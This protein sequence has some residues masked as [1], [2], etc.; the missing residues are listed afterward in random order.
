V[1]HFVPSMLR[2]FLGHGPSALALGSCDALRY[3]FCSGEA[4]PSPLVGDF[5]AHAPVGAGLHNLY[6]PTEAA[7]DVTHWPC[8]A[9]VADPLPIGQA[10]S[11]T[12]LY[13]LD[14][15]LEPVPVGVVGE[16]WIGGVQVSRGYLGRPGL[17]A[18]N[19]MADPHGGVAGAR[20][21]RTGDLARRRPDGA[22]VYL[23]RTDHQVKLRG[24]RIELGEI[25]T[26]LLGHGSVLAAAVLL[27]EDRTGDPRLVAYVVAEGG[28]APPDL[29]GH[30]RVTLAEHMVPSDV[31]VLDALPVTS[32]G[33]L[34][35][36][37]LPA[38]SVASGSG[39][40]AS[41]GPEEEV[42]RSV[43]AGVLGREEV[44]PEDNF[45]ALGGH[46][47]LA[48]QAV[49]RLRAALHVDMPANAVFENPTP[50]RIAE[51]ARSGRVG[52]GT[53]I[54]RR[55]DDATILPSL[56]QRQLWFL[57][58]L[59][60]SKAYNVPDGFIVDGP[61]DIIALSGA[62]EDIMS[63]HEALRAVM[64]ERDGEPVVEVLAPP[65][66]RIGVDRLVTDDPAELDSWF[67]R[68][69]LH[70]FKIDIEPPIRLAVASLRDG[71]HAIAIVMHHLATDGASAPVLYRDLSDAYA[72]RKSGRRFDREDPP[73]GYYDWAMWQRDR[74][75]SGSMEAAV[76][77]VR[78]RLA[79]APD[80]L[81]LP[82]DFQRPDAGSFDGAMLRVAIP[83]DLSAALRGC[84]RETGST[85]FMV[86]AAGLGAFLGRLCDQEDL[87]I[88][89]P[90]SGRD[91][92]ETESLV[93]FMVNTIPLRLRPVRST[94]LAEFL[95]ATRNDV[96]ASFADGDLPLDRVVQ[97]LS[98]NRVHSRTPLFQVLLVL[99][100]ADRMSLELDQASVTPVNIDT[101]SARYD[102]TF[103][104]DD[105]G[106]GL[107]LVLHYA[108]DLFR[109]DTAR[110]LADGLNRVLRALAD[111]RSKSIR[112]LDLLDHDGRCAETSGP[113]VRDLR[114]APDG[115]LVSRFRQIATEHAGRPAVEEMTGATR[116]Y[117]ELDTLSDRVAAGLRQ[118]G[119][120]RGDRIGLFME[121]GGIQVAAMLAVLKAGGAYVP[122]EPE[123]PTIRL[124]M[125]LDAAD[126]RIVV[127]DQS[128]PGGG[129]AGATDVR[130]LAVDTLMKAE[131]TGADG[132][133]AVR[134][135]AEVA[136][137]P[138]ISGVSGQPMGVPISDRAILRSAVD[139]GFTDV[140]SGRRV[141]YISSAASDAVVH[142]IW[143]P[144]LNG[145]VCVVV[146]QEG[147][148]IPAKLGES[149][150]VQGIDS[151]YLTSEMFSQAAASEINILG[152]AREVL[153][154]GGAVDVE[155]AR[156]AITRWPSVRFVHVHGTMETAGVAS[157][158]VVEIP[159]SIDL[160]VPIGRPSRAT[161]LYVLDQDLNPVPRGGHGELYVGGEGLA[162]GYLRAPARTA[163]SFLADPFTDRSGARMYRTRELVRRRGDGALE[164][165][166]RLDRRLRLQGHWVDPS[167]IEVAIRARTPNAAEVFVDVLAPDDVGAENEIV[168]WVTG[169]AIDPERERELRSDLSVTLPAWMVPARVIGLEALPIGKDG[170]V[171]RALLP[172]LGTGGEVAVPRKE[173]ETETEKALAEIWSGLL[174]GAPVEADDTFFDVGGHSLLGVKLVALV[175]QHLGVTLELRAVFEHSGLREMATLIDRS[176]E[177]GATNVPTIK[178]RA[179]RGS[180]DG[181]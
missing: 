105:D 148:T 140:T 26:A 159:T 47:L 135:G 131:I 95:D 7:I 150:S 29:L 164:Y 34:D 169:P 114:A 167:E 53:M 73:L 36:G 31:V 180:T 102:L 68:Q 79:S 15:A 42:A 39:A 4:L 2:T 138:F 176:R 175:R 171:D 63:R 23:G 37:A 1:A 18:S 82:V 58:R 163:E 45:F 111:D 181:D 155:A 17:T 81:E 152:D 33:K 14:G 40:G 133:D 170:K 51:L 38:P 65:S 88:G 84:A 16:L 12:S 166:G 158:Q 107:D 120:R 139:P 69:S 178:R 61:L 151:L 124:S 110:M 177:D 9:P 72:A 28:V 94:T 59:E 75:A 156:A 21:Y 141:A 103:A 174:N 134:D 132:D 44:G 128:L 130:S 27:R 162:D 129:F 101:V 30:L 147:A 104:F 24:F 22:L 127:C 119:V 98:P 57:C 70:S 153:V 149:M 92:A 136:Y 93:G 172:L 108:A 43:F 100:P 160:S 99:Q 83:I 91:R 10:I 49:G 64:L 55:L 35:R 157:F 89:A 96:L 32:N 144:L 90:V 168:A 118:A 142:K 13:V 85:L 97:A 154:G 126:V 86:L 66:V 112:D 76:E 145:G 116:T 115:D 117:Q 41:R 179:R 11:N 50:R 137:V 74:A 25:E 173:I 143:A 20:M 123:L 67:R 106:R 46:S 113:D 54:G 78:A 125:M 77:R 165:L 3:V 6:G 19:F 62:V 60:G 109:E 5:L 87:V 146:N 121:R 161:S 52:A 56:G 8:A 48:V 71:R 80:T 122:L